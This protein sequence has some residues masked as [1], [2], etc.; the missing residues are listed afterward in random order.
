MK[1][2]ACQQGHFRVVELLLSAGADRNAANKNGATPIFIA[3]SC[4]HLNIVELLIAA[5]ADTN[6]ATKDGWTPLYVASSKGYHQVV[7]VLLA[8]G[9]D[10]SHRVGGIWPFGTTSHDIAKKNSYS[11]VVQLLSS[12]LPPS[13]VA[14]FR[15]RQLQLKSLLDAHTQ[16]YLSTKELL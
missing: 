5:G 1:Y 16:Q 10:A 12:P 11:S 2:V 14:S 7:L 15:N 8:A 6:A 13:S 4:G 3:S 9:A